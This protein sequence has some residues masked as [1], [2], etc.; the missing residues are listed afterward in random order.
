MSNDKRNKRWDKSEMAMLDAITA[1]YVKDGAVQ[2]QRVPVDMWPPGRTIGASC[3][4]LSQ[5]GFRAVGLPHEARIQTPGEWFKNNTGL[6]DMFV[7]KPERKT[8]ACSPT[9]TTTTWFWG[10]YTKTVEK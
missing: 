2:L 1:R 5:M 7:A 10:L 8:A 6:D 9:K 3:F 4:Q